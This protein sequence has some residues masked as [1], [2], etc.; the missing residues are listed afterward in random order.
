VAFASYFIFYSLHTD[1]HVSLKETY[2][3]L[4]LLGWKTTG[5]A[6]LSHQLPFA[7]SQISAASFSASRKIYV[8]FFFIE[9]IYPMVDAA[10]KALWL[11][12][13]NYT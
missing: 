10:P 8:F 13:I 1:C 12:T 7:N 9:H 6:S 3:C 4:A 11:S 5:H 2:D